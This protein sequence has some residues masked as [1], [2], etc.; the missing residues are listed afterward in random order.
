MLCAVVCIEPAADCR[1][2]S[3]E[4]T[5]VSN[6]TICASMRVA[7]SDLAMRSLSWSADSARLWIMLSRNTSSESAIA[8]ISSFWWLW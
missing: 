5:V 6:S 8:A 7:R 1:L 4:R 2:S 3:A